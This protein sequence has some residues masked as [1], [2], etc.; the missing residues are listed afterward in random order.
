MKA[1]RHVFISTAIF[2]GAA[3]FLGLLLWGLGIDQKKIPSAVVGKP[4]KDFSIKWIKGQEFVPASKGENLTLAELKGRPVVLNFWASWCVSCREEALE[5]QA[6]WQSMQAEVLVV[7][8][9]IQDEAE[10]A[11]LFAQRYGKTYPLGLDVDGKVSIDYGVSGVP[12]TFLIDR[13]GIIRHKEIGPVSAAM[14]KG[15]VAKIL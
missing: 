13:Q 11:L 5:L 12:E 8:V 15:L 14:L 10:S 4:A 3:V 2:V 9:A 7:G 1:T 6:Y